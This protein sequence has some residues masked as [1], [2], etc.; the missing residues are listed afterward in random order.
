MKFPVFNHETAKFDTPDQHENID[1]DSEQ[2][3]DDLASLAALLC[4]TPIAAINFIDTHHQFNSKVGLDFQEKP[5]DEEFFQTY[6]QQ[7]D[8]LIIPD[9]LAN[10]QF[11]TAKAVISEPYIRFYAAVPLIVSGKAIIGTLY[12]ADQVPRQI[13]PKQLTGLQYISRLIVRQLKIRRNLKEI[14]RLNTEYTQT[15]TALDH[16]ESTLQSFFESAPMMMGIV[17]LV[18]NDILHISDNPKTAKFFGLTPQAMQNRLAREIGADITHLNQWINYYRQ[19]EL[20]QAPVRFEYTQEIPRGKVCLSATV[21]AIDK[22]HDSNQQFAYIVEDITERKQVEDELRWKETLLLS[23]NS[24]SPLALYVVDDRTDEILYFN[25]KLCAIW[26]IEHLKERMQTRELKNQDILANCFQLITDSESFLSSCQA[27]KFENNRSVIEDELSFTDGR[28]I[29]RFSSQIRDKNDQ[30]FGRLYIYEDITA[31]KQAEHKLRE[32]ATLLDIVTDAIVVQNLDNKILFWNKSAE[33]LYGWKAEEV[34]NQNAN[35]LWN[36]EIESQQQKIYQ[37]VFI[38][39]YWQGEFYKHQKSGAEIIVESRWNLVY[40][41]NSIA[42]SILI[43]E[44]DITHKK[45]LEQQFLR[46]Q[47]M[48][49]IGTLVSGIAHDLNNVFSPILMAVHLLQNPT[50]NSQFPQILSIV[51]SNAKRGANLVRQVLSFARGIQGYHTVIQVKYLITEMQ[52][53]VKQT[54][55]KTITVNT[56]IQ[57]NLSPICGDITQLDQV[58]INLCLNARDAMLNGGI[59]TIIAENIWIDE[60]Y[61]KIH[62]DAQVGSYIVI[63]VTDTGIGIPSS[64]LD[65][66]FEPFFTTKEFGKGTGLGLSTVIGIVKGH[67][68]FITVS[69]TLRKGTEFS[70]YLPAVD[71]K[72]TKSLTEI[73]T[74]IGNGEWILLVD[75]EVSI[76]ETTKTTLENHN[77]K[78]VTAS[79]GEKA[80]KLYN[81]HQDAIRI[82]IIDMIMPIMDGITTIHKLRKINPQLIIIAIS[83]LI[84]TEYLSLQQEFNHITFLSKPFTVQELL[85]TIQT[86]IS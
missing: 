16:S 6:T 81:Q 84:T 70:V 3:F 55:P 37:T 30:Y 24:V 10:E 20:T 26:K 32:Q 50:P 29:R 15:Q 83:G 48:E 74:P 18:D 71:T 11:A 13:S 8:I 36:H 67:G 62:L 19:A 80:T 23:M 65:R 69:S 49:S 86:V 78:V 28:I 58:L 85:K 42:K 40:D 4:D 22:K 44:T 46:A 54:F 75:D 56:E 77:Y 7:D 57:Q 73:A 43:I 12:V 35:H 17:E 38:N 39:G 47:R 5:L 27:L 59:L 1:I 21:S 33:K 76:L 25:E 60:T 34:I 63:K 72:I 14:S 68:G 82:A 31:R 41:D 9:T 45:Q 61:Q 2:T 79:S 66:I 51:E 64:I 52:Q 53:I